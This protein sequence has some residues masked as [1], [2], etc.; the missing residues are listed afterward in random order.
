MARVE[1]FL[2]N[3]LGIAGFNTT[4]L[5]S[6]HSS[7]APSALAQIEDGEEVMHGV[8]G[9]EAFDVP[10]SE[11]WPTFHALADSDKA[12]SVSVGVDP[13]SAQTSEAKDEEQSRGAQVALTRLD[14][15]Q[16]KFEEEAHPVQDGHGKGSEECHLLV[17][18]DT[19]LA[20][21]QEGAGDG[22][23]SADGQ[24]CLNDE[25]ERGLALEYVPDETKKMGELE[26]TEG[27]S[28]HQETDDVD[29]NDPSNEARRERA[30][31][32]CVS[33]VDEKVQGCEDDKSKDHCYCL[34]N[35]EQSKNSSSDSGVSRSKDTSLVET[36]QKGRIDIDEKISNVG[37][38]LRSEESAV[39]SQTEDMAK[40]NPTLEVDGGFVEEQLSNHGGENLTLLVKAL[41]GSVSPSVD[42]VMEDF[43]WFD[44]PGL[45]VVKVEEGLLVFVED[46]QLG[47]VAMEGLKHK[48]SISEQVENN[49]CINVIISLFQVLIVADPSSGLFTL[50]FTDS[51]CMRYTATRNHFLQFCKD[52]EQ[53][54]LSR[55]SGLQEVLVSFARKEAAVEAFECTMEDENFPGLNVL[56]ACRPSL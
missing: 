22:E 50:T 13:A 43:A 19:G 32:K 8:A 41:P 44:S 20:Q 18:E 51:K 54:L 34:E 45:K 27:Q 14:I 23:E 1:D 6:D 36:Q 52:G 42:A 37:S 35:V 9:A 5:H 15:H 48:Y 28:E 30:E 21:V 25:I 7:A 38:K 46:G 24:E 11:M 3:S 55:G 17:S 16:Q 49:H 53:P 12:N 40:E 29:D 39:S 31:G 33:M 2:K 26:D 4:Q 47:R 10:R 56:P